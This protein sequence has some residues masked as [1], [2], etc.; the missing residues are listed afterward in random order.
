MLCVLIFESP[1]GGDYNEYTQYTIFNIKR[2]SSLIIPN[3]HLC[4]FSKGLKGQF[5]TAVVNE[6]SFSSH[7]SSTV[8]R[9]FQPV[10]VTSRDVMAMQR[11]S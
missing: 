1:H 9:V 5:E 10:R 6:Q 11:A 3:L 7:R 8:I 4:D 2:K